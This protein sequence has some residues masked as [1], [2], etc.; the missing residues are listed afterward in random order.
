MKIKKK[1]ISTLWNKA[2]K[3]LQEYHRSIGGPCYGQG[4]SCHGRMEVV[5]HHFHWGQSTALRLE[6][7]NLVPLCQ[8]CHMAFH[9]GSHRVKVNYEREMKE[10]WGQDWE[11]RL[12]AIEQAH[13]KMGMA[14]KR[15]FLEQ[16][17]K[18]YKELTVL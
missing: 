1:K 3:A 15:E 5:H 17:I 7:M 8:P 16:A 11:E 4:L 6:E 18:N 13:V 9:N 12:L 14:D 2:S 10:V